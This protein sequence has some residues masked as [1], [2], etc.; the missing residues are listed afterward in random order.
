ML[1]ELPPFE[2]VEAESIA[3]AIGWLQ[4]YGT[5][6][7][8]IAGGTDLLGLMKD[9]ITGPK[10]PLPDLLVNIKRVRELRGTADLPG[11]GVS[12]GAATTLREIERDPLMRTRF[13]ALTEA[14]ASV[15]TSH[16]RAVGTIGGNL[17][18]RPWCWYFRHPRFECFKRGGRQCFAI[19]GQNGSYFSVLNLGICV[20]AHPS[21]TAPA[22][23]ALGA[24]LELAGPAGRRQVPVEDFFR[25]PR[26]VEET[27]LAPDEILSRIVVPAPGPGTRTAFVKSRPRNTWDFAL[28]SVAVSV[29]AP[30]SRCIAAR[31]VLGGVAPSPYRARQAEEVLVGAAL[32]ERTIRQAADA[33]IAGARP[34]RMNAYKVDLTRALVVRALSAVCAP[35]ADRAS[36]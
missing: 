24:D 22:L 20:M 30:D 28:T 31:V 3:D 8:L 18:Q 17:C 36:A 29:T 16:I 13:R 10:M 35:S 23:V 19:P 26:S 5:R 6:A 11:G 27:V 9:R 33:A 12:V 14:A 7:K 2:H 1:H 34:L 32:D 25:G 15:A 21:D 4:R